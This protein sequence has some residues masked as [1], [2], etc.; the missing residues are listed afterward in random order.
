MLHEIASQFYLGTRLSV[1]DMPYNLI[2]LAQLAAGRSAQVAAVL[3][4]VDHVHRLHELGL[5]DG[6]TIEM[7]QPGS[8]CILKLAGQRLCFRADEL[9]SVLVEAGSD[10]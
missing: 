10:G 8:P 9:L 1:S 3:G 4:R 2:P 6:V 5:R 7:L